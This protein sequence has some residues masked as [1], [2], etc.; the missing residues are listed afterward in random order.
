MA[1]SQ[2]LAPE[3]VYALCSASDDLP[4]PGMSNHLRT[5]SERWIAY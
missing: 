3:Q 4:S 2:A 5:L 1:V